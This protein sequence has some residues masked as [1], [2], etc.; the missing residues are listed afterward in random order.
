[1]IPINPPSKPCFFEKFRR[2]FY[3]FD[4]FPYRHPFMASH[5]IVD[6]DGLAGFLKARLF[7]HDKTS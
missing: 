3:G 1:M 2:C 4:I 7:L 5:Q 6:H